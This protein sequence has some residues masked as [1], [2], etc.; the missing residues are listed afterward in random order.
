M[1]IT[2]VGQMSSVIR[3]RNGSKAHIAPTFETLRFEV[4]RIGPS[5]R[6]VRVAVQRFGSLSERTEPRS[7]Q[8]GVVMAQIGST[9][10]PST[11][12]PKRKKVP[13]SRRLTSETV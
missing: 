3:L 8:S 5:I 12:E 6:I 11:Q 13:F 4:L 1:P 9:P 10:A 2:A 7:G